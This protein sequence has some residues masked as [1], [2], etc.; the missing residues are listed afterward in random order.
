M[1]FFLRFSEEK[2]PEPNQP[3]NKLSAPSGVPGVP[4]ESENA[5]ATYMDVAVMRCLFIS[6]W[7]E[8]GVFWALMFL[9]RRYRFWLFFVFTRELIW[10]RCDA[11]WKGS[12]VV[13]WPRI[14]RRVSV[15]TPCHFPK[16]RSP[17]VEAFQPQQQPLQTRKNLE[18]I[19]HRI[20]QVSNALLVCQQRLLEKSLSAK[21][22]IPLAIILEA[23]MP[24]LALKPSRRSCSLRSFQ[25]R[26]GL[27]R[28][29][30]IMA[31]KLAWKTKRKSRRRQHKL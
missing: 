10:H 3:E 11:G 21:R 14:T 8:D 17:L 12:R 5:L 26:I 1:F 9:N 24:V 13:C 7:S 15:A 18:V 4:S 16:L 25:N 30:Q 23:F 2:S 20:T 22:K 27:S 28:Q 29:L 6:H 31:T 19:C